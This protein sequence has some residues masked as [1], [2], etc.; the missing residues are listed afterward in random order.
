MEASTNHEAVIFYFS[1]TGNTWWAAE[2]LAE[3][4]SKE[5]FKASAY[6]IENIDRETAAL[7]IKNAAVLGFGYPIYGSDLPLS[8][9]NFIRQ[10]PAS[11]YKEVFVFCTQWF[12]SGNGAAAAAKMLAQKG[13]EVKWAEHFFMPNNLSAGLIPMPYTNKPEKTQKTLSKAERRIKRFAGH[14]ADNTSFK[15][16][17]NPLSSVLGATMRTPYRY[18]FHRL[19]NNIGIDWEK[20]DNCGEC[21]ALCPAG[22]LYYDGDEIK[23]KGTCINC[24]RCYSFCPLTAMTYMGRPHQK[25]RKK[26]YKGPTKD[27]T[28][29]SL[30]K[31]TK[32]E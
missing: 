25:S 17:F 2:K 11:L 31:K 16:G 1:G 21:V 20:C 9:K 30:T 14:I 22:N 5:G 7:L 8:M 27:F 4:L 32:P 28:P 24:L 12:W 29:Y 19:Q 6:S 23:I 3:A 18:F 13:F 10:L 26:P 15:R